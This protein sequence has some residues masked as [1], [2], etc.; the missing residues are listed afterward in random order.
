MYDERNDDKPI[1][2][3][4]R[5]AERHPKIDDKKLLG[6]YA[7]DPKLAREVVPI[8]QKEFLIDMIK[9]IR[10]DIKMQEQTSI[11]SG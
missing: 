6:D 10:H 11:V 8:S 2:N 1:F 7:I 9:G 5:E 3:I 4:T